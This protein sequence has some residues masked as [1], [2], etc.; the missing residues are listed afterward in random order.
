MNIL[1]MSGF[2]QTLTDK[3]LSGDLSWDSLYELQE[4]TEENNKFLSS[5]LFQDEFHTINFPKSFYC[6]NNSSGYVYL[7]NETFESGYDGS[8]I[9]GPNIYIQKDASSKVHKLTVELGQIYQLQN[10]ILYSKEQDDKEI[11]NF[12]DNYYN[13]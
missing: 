4:T 6:L 3:T 12:I 1:A 5:T 13:E 2:I 8:V 9:S 11:Q 10:A 7:I